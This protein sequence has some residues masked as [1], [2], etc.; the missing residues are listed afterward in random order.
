MILW[1][2][3]RVGARRGRELF[4]QK[5]TVTKRFNI[6]ERGVTVTCMIR[7]HVTPGSN[8]GAPTK[9]ITIFH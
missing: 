9:L 6:S 4:Q 1:K 2:P 7:V 8:P 3:E 5:K